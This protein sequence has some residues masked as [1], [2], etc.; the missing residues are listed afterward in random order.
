MQVWYFTV[1]AETA[2]AART[3][4]DLLACDESPHND[5]AHDTAS[6]LLVLVPART[7]GSKT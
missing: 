3:E 7:Q 2:D 6:E 1:E 5:F 4:A